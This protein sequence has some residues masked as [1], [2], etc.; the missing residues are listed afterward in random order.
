MGETTGA[1]PAAVYKAAHTGEFAYLETGDMCAH[2]RD[3]SYNFMAGYHGVDGS[4]PLIAYLV[5]IGVADAAVQDFD[6]DIVGSHRA[7]FNGERGEGTGFGLG[8]E[9]VDHGDV[10]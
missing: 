1:N 2:F 8:G 6:F 4:A 7:A 5:D 9:G 10:I 3:A